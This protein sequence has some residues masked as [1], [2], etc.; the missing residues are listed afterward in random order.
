MLDIILLAI[1]VILAVAV[2]FIV[3]TLIELK[4]TAAQAT[5][6]LK[7]AEETLASTLEETTETLK[8]VRNITEDI[9]TITSDTRALSSSLGK[10]ADNVSGVTKTID[11]VTSRTTG[12][13]S[14]LRAGIAAGVSV[15]THALISRKRSDK[16]E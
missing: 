7:S 9:N 13:F 12:K 1:V 11:K 14:A 10:V 15:I 16:D 3:S 4:K 8:S 6:F 2:G 5:M